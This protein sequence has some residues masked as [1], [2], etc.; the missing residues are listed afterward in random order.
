MANYLVTLTAD[1]DN[2][3][4]PVSLL[5]SMGGVTL[6]PETAEQIS[7]LILKNQSPTLSE[8]GL[9][10]YG[11]LVQTG[12]I[13]VEVVEPASGTTL[14]TFAFVPQPETELLQ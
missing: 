14:M 11:S 8:F 12:I 6:T 3:S 4:A 7:Q 9:N 10:F 13:H 2:D 1:G 5:A